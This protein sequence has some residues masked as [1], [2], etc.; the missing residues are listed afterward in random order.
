MYNILQN[1]LYMGFDFTTLQKQLCAV[2]HYGCITD[3]AIAYRGPHKVAEHAVVS[4][5]SGQDSNFQNIV[6]VLGRK[7]GREW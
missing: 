5:V 7:E 1:I 6:H 3:Q 2:I 4:P